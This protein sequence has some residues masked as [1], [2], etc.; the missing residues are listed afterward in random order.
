MGRAPLVLLPGMMCDARLFAP[1]AA[2]LA[3]VAEAWTGDIGRSTS[4]EAI[5]RDVLTEAPFDRFAL[6]GL[7]MGGIVS[8][9]ILRIAPER[10]TRLAL[11][12]TN[13][14]AE[15]PERQAAREPQIARAKAGALREVLVDEMKPNY[16]GPARR[17]DAAL[18]DLLLAMGLDLG[19]DV[20]ERQSLALRDRPDST[21]ALRAYPGPSLVLCGR[22]DALCPPERHA[23]MA[24]LLAS[25][26][27][28]VIEEAGHLP[29]LETP[30]AVSLA[31]RDW[32]SRA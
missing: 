9:A 31:L 16:L 4:V 29:T 8:M 18:L 23:E 28:E 24:G 3:D 26:R 17:D 2:A 21:E 27:L 13:H 1:Q 14:R 22:H 19:P 15:T 5:A 12:D 32:I 30:D 7:S 20:F 11:L 10:V 6:A 25:A